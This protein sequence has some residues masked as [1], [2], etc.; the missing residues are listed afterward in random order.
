MAGPVLLDGTQRLIIAGCGTMA[1]A[2]LHRW[3]E[4]GLRAHQVTA[5]RP[6]GRDV[7]P[8]VA[9][10]TSAAALQS[11]TPADVLLLGMKPQQLAA[12]LPDIAPLIGPNTIILSIL[13]GLR[14]GALTAMLPPNAGVVRIMPNLAV[15]RGNGVALLAGDAAS[16]AG[17]CAARLCVPLGL[18]HWAEDDGDTPPFDTL[19]A[20]TGCAPAYSFRFA[21]A[22][23]KAATVMGIGAADADRLARATVAGAATMAA[24]DPRSLTDMARAVAS[25][26]GMTQAGLD[27]LD[28]DNALN[29]LMAATLRAAADRG[30]ALAAM[31]ARTP[32]HDD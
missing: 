8:G 3:L 10:V 27:V 32:A 24:A 20:L 14:R 26:G 29:A 23:A 5:V 11:G 16:R 28:A 6:S 22:L 25:P 13:A 31:A 1:G 2:M 18:V 30:A 4:S 12:A 17:Q 21:E 19:T 7:A 9:V 15:A